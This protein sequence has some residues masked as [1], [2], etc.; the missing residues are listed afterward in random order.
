MFGKLINLIAGDTAGQSLNHR[1]FNSLCLLGGTGFAVAGVFCVLGGL[2]SAVSALVGAIA[3]FYFVA[4]VLARFLGLL[5]FV[6]FPVLVFAVFSLVVLW[7]VSGGVDGSVPIIFVLATVILIAVVEG[8]Y[9]LPAGLCVVTGFLTAVILEIYFPHWVIP[10]PSDAVRR[11]DIIFTALLSCVVIVVAI[12]LLR[13][14]YESERRVALEASRVRSEFLSTMSH[15]IRTPMNSVVGMSYLLLEE[16]PR[17]DQVENLRLLQFSAENLLVLLNDILDLSKIEAGKIDLE[18]APFALKDLL[19]NI[20]ALL[21]PEA[22][23]RALQFDLLL[24]ENTPEYVQGDATRLGQVLTNLV[25]NAVKFTE[26]G[27][28]SLEIE[29]RRVPGSGADLVDLQFRVRDTGIG[30][31]RADLNK[32]FDSFSQASSSTTRRFGGTGLGLT[33]SR[34]L[35]E[36]MGSQIELES[37]PGSGSCFSFT[38]Q[39]R[40]VNAVD[41]SNPRRASGAP[42][43]ADPAKLRDAKDDF[44]SFSQ[45]RVLLVDDFEPNVLLARKF[46]LK[47]GLQ[48]D[49][50]EDG[51][52]ALDKFEGGEYDIVLM[53]LQ[54][55]RMDG[56][57]ATR[58]IRAMGDSRGSVPV[59]ALSAAALPEEISQA[60]AAGVSDYVSKPFNPRELNAKIARLLSTP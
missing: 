4:Y 34:R 48:V 10:Y 57:E 35:L 53:D 17:P 55:P 60:R 13:R 1:V 14:N 15:E 23:A 31:E 50:A 19:R 12:G 32:I 37:E 52:D 54:M 3:A 11:A 9:S 33:I 18:A 51:R 27:R 46:L 8:R 58:S 38:L 42:N 41:A 47:W 43:A 28:V 6:F 25:A 22:T 24:S 20:H 29:T 49:S 39:T 44:E 36:M 2:H 30:I 56:F 26:R 21:A 5:R 45:Q 7:F 59:L 40:V 16:N